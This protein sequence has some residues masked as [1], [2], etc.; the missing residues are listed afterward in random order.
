MSTPER[1]P[2]EGASILQAVNTDARCLL[3]AVAD[4][5]IETRVVLEKKFQNAIRYDSIAVWQQ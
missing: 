5:E 1:I 2:E 3:K 4:P